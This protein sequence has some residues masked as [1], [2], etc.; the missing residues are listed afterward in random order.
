MILENPSIAAITVEYI[1]ANETATVWREIEEAKALRV[2]QERFPIV[3]GLHRPP[4]IG[5]DFWCVISVDSERAKPGMI[6]NLLLGAAYCLPRPK[7]LIVVDDDVDIYRLEDV[8]W[9]L[10]M[11]V[12]PERDSFF[13]PNTM[14]SGLDPCGPSPPHGVS[15]FGAEWKV[16]RIVVAKRRISSSIS[17]TV[18]DMK[19]STTCST[20]R[21][22]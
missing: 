18:V 11:R 2:L 3:K 15:F 1:T 22:L 20:P 21:P 10:S 5:R 9:A 16:G 14:T 8:L 4:Q 17:L 7:F 6:G 19:P 12:N 13:A